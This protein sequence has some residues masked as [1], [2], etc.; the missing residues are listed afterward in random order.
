MTKT[1]SYF[2]EKI[3]RWNEEENDRVLPWK[4]EKDPYK[5]WLSE[6]ILQQTRAEQGLPYYESFVATYLDVH[7]LANAPEQE[8]FRLWQGLGYYSRCRN[9]IATAKFVSSELEGNFPN[10]YEELMKLKGVGSYTAAAIAS[11]AFGQPVPVIDGN[12][13]R[14]ISRYFAEASPIDTALGKAVFLTH[15]NSVFDE[16]R[17][18][19]FNQAIMDFGA[20]VCVPRNP[21]CTECPLAAR[22]K[23]YQSGSID[24]FP[25]KSLKIKKRTRIFNY[26]VLLVGAEI[27]I[28]QRTQKD[29][30]QGLHEFLLVEGNG[31]IPDFLQERNSIVMELPTTT[32]KQTLSHQYIESRFFII[33]LKK[34]PREM[35]GI[36]LWIH[37]KTINSYAFPKSIVSFLEENQYF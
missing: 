21:K 1:T 18:S 26:Y 15:V 19:D 16:S 25:V 5:I 37:K 32:I 3:I 24:L 14:V 2:T 36:G 27:Y 8:I 6:V 4:G 10:C 13:Y 11:F 30:W 35:E 31:N 22:C 12:V 17:P 28:R 33:H 34:K 20:T 7:A 9:L 29:I 23:S